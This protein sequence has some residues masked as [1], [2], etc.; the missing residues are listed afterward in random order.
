M[1]VKTA[2]FKVRHVR[3]FSQIINAFARQ[4]FWGL[5]EK[6]DVLNLLS[7]D[8]LRVAQQLNS[9]K[10][11]GLPHHVS[12]E[13]QFSIAARLRTCFEELG[14]A[15]VKLGQILAVRKDLVP[16]AFTDQFSKLHSDVAPMDF[17]LVQ[18]VL[19]QELG[20][21]LFD[22][23]KS[24]DSKALAAGSIGQIHLAEL[25]SG[26]RIVLKVQRP[27]IATLI[28]ADLDL[29][30]MLASAAAKY[31]PELKALDPLGLVRQLRNAL[32]A[33]LDFVREAANSAR[34]QKNFSEEKDIIVPKVFWDYTTTKVIGQEYL[35]GFH[36]LDKPALEKAGIAP[37]RVVEQGLEM[38]LKMVFIDGLYH[39]DLHPGNLL[40][41]NDGRMG[42]LDFG[43]TVRISM[44]LRMTLAKLMQAIMEEDY[45]SAARC[46]L[47]A[48]KNPGH[49]NLADFEND[50]A[51][52]IGPFVGLQLD[53]VPSAKI[54]WDLGKV[55]AKHNAPLP[56]ELSLFFKTIS[57]FE[58]IGKEL[59][60]KFDII[61][62]C[63]DFADTLE[64]ESSIV[65]SYKKQLNLL[66]QDVS[67]LL[68]FSPIQIR[69]LLNQTISG[70]LGLKFSSRDLEKVAT[71]VN[72][73]SARLAIGIVVGAL[74]IASAQLINVRQNITGFPI[75]TLGL[76]GFSLAGFLGLYIV[77]SILR[78]RK[79]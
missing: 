34:V 73:A 28:T 41:L 78:G 7:Q 40:I 69:Q 24:I 67:S 75:A 6:L 58:A 1:E 62:Y 53:K 60:P 38:F 18:S 49:M 4:G 5:L 71:S 13:D 52:A 77:I 9:V 32:I 3:R 26:E 8:Q 55:S 63:R 56:T 57:S 17:A 68:R 15:F 12:Y 42:V 27:E 39:G 36:V 19:M 70:E 37:Q 66:F 10:D 23:L 30:E 54:L 44:Q 59:V 20:K 33:E 46:F 47:E 35:E 45:Q 61:Y 48:S 79:F 43:L 65:D 25:A 14:P 11:D 50:I 64:K 51:N 2:Q 76:I 74:I 29:I 16:P 31:L 22:S 72:V 21:D